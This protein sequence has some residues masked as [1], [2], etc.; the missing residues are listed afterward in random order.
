MGAGG[1]RFESCH[2]DKK[3]SCNPRR[4]FISRKYVYIIYSKIINKYYFGFTSMELGERLRRHLTSHKGF[5]RKSERLGGSLLVSNC[6]LNYVV[7]CISL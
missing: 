7:L 2:P 1:R 3:P 6:S 4:F 5:Y